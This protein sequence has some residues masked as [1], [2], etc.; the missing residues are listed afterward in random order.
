MWETLFS[1]FQVTGPITYPLYAK[2]ELERYEQE[3]N[4]RLPR[5]YREFCF[6]FGPGQ[7]V[8]PFQFNIAAPGPETWRSLS[9]CRYLNDFAGG[10]AAADSDDP[11]DISRLS[12]ALYFG[13]DISLHFYFWDTGEIT[14]AQEGEF[15]IY[16]LQRLGDIHRLADTYFDFITKTCLVDGTP[17]DDPT[18]E[19]RRNFEP[20]EGPF[21]PVA[22]ASA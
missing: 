5:S 13:S 12:R 9:E 2:R 17:G 16:V 22:M 4:R 14:S 20:A 3:V 18:T 7:I 8:F 19:R 11:Q 21:R 10:S 1:C 15:A 6:V